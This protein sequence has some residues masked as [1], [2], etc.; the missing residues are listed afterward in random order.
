[1][2]MYYLMRKQLNNNFSWSLL[3]VGWM[4]PLYPFLTMCRNST[5]QG[6][7]IHDICEMHRIDIGPASIGAPP[8]MART[9]S[10][11]EP[12]F[13]EG[14]TSGY[15]HVVLVGK[16][17]DSGARTTPI[18]QQMLQDH[19]A[20]DEIYDKSRLAST[21]VLTAEMDGM[22]VYVPDRIIDDCP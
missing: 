11:T 5:T 9:D 12:T 15:D 8:E 14:I 18:E 16:G 21:V 3:F 7:S 17:T 13:G 22:T 2:I 1:M 10:W 4:V 20:F 19:W 6:K